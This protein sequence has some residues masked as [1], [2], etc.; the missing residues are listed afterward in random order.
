MAA[1]S[2]STLHFPRFPADTASEVALLQA[3]QKL[4]PPRELIGRRGLTARG[5]DFGMSCHIIDADARVTAIVY[6]SM[7][8]SSL[9]LACLFYIMN[10]RSRCRS[11]VGVLAGSMGVLVVW[12][13]SPTWLGVSACPK[14]DA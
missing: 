2:S 8:M 4:Q 5:V 13:N 6:M 9:C 10:S 11:S 3:S 12:A 14:H 1:F 7:S